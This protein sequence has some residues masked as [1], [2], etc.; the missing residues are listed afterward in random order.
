MPWY[1]EFLREFQFEV[2]PWVIAN[3]DHRYFIEIFIRYVR[4]PQPVEQCLWIFFPA[5]CLQIWEADNTLIT[6]LQV[7]MDMRPALDHLASVFVDNSCAL[8]SFISFLIFKYPSI[9]LYVVG[10]AANCQNLL[11]RLQ[12]ACDICNI[13]GPFSP[14]GA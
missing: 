2:R 12:E 14:V 10:V 5:R 13:P 4:A 8:L 7:A 3:S 9:L 6:P 1:V 11:H